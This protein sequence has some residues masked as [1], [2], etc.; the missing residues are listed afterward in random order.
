MLQIVLMKFLE[1]R[2]APIRR[3]ALEAVP[4]HRSD[5]TVAVRFAAKIEPVDWQYR[6]SGDRT[7]CDQGNRYAIAAPVETGDPCDAGD[8]HV[9]VGNDRGLAENDFIAL[10][11]LHLER[12]A[13]S[14]DLR[15][16]KP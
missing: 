1:R 6:E 9:G 14:F 3:H 8:Q 13:Q 7:R 5:P 16:G 10:E 4:V 2:F 15:R 12:T 11:I